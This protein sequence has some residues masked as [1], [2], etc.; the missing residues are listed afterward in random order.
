MLIPPRYLHNNAQVPDKC[1][2]GNHLEC[3]L[4]SLHVQVLKRA[5]PLVP[6]GQSYCS[7]NDNARDLHRVAGCCL[8]A[9]TSAL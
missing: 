9:A 7:V 8:L 6:K 4:I 5:K 3:Q 2:L 1:P